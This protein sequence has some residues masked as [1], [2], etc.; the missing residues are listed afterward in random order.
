MSL[1]TLAAVSVLALAVG[2]LAGCGDD[3][4][5]AQA[6]D[7][8]TTPA[9]PAS[10]PP[11]STDA[12]SPTAP[13]SSSSPPAVAVPVYFTGRTPVG[14]RLFR[15]FRQVEADNPVDEALALLG[16]GDAADPD[17]STLLPGGGLRLVSYDEAAMVSVPASMASRPSGMSAKQAQLAVQQV[18]YT[19]QGVLQKRIPVAFTGPG[20]DSTSFLGLGAPSETNGFTA[21]K[22]LRVLA[23]VNVTEPEQDSQPG[24]HFTASG[25]ASSFEGTVPWE[26]RD[27]SGKAVL[28]GSAQ[29]EG[30]LGK[31]WPWQTDVDVSALAP[32]HYTFAAMTDDPS[33]GEGPGPTEDTKTFTVS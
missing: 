29:A 3:D 2:G 18:V 7:P 16:A 33:D 22:P 4:G 8:T 21:A 9:G 26:V 17:Y 30:W 10:S 32:G 15:E 24:D 1:R 25:V 28:S 13:T 20:G 27:S 23:L 11:A 12:G 19:V 14:T 5:G 31:L 6:A